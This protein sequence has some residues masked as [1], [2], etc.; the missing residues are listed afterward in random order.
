MLYTH[1]LINQLR[2]DKYRKRSAREEMWKAQGCDGFWHTGDGGIYSNALRKSVYGALIGAEKITRERG[3]F[4]PSI[5]AFDFDLDGEREYL[6]QGTEINC[7]VDTQGACVF[8]LDYLPKTWNYLDTF[9]RRQDGYQSDGLAFE[10]CR[11]SAFMDMLVPSGITLA[12]AVQGSFGLGRFCGKERYELVSLDRVHQEAVFRLS[13]DPEACYG[14]IEIIKKIS[15]KKNTLCVDYTLTNQGLRTERFNFIP[16]IDLSLSGESPSEQ[17]ILQV[18]GGDRKPV[19]LDAVGLPSVDG[20]IVQDLRNEVTINLGSTAP[21][22]AWLF[23]YR[24][25]CPVDGVFEDCY[26]STAIMPVKPLALAPGES[27]NSAFTLRFGR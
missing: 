18:R 10:G 11:R 4:I 12:D 23:P 27:W 25:R 17:R 20:L 7:Y 15:L 24:T 8:E 3:V 26:Q 5:V 21:F 13:A 16:Q 9:A 22:E 6:F 1:I 14:N 19:Q 2:G